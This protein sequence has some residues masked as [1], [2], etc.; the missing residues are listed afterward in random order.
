MADSDEE[1]PQAPLTP[2]EQGVKRDEHPVQSR[3]ADSA[4]ADRAAVKAARRCTVLLSSETP[5]AAGCVENLQASLIAAG[6]DTPRA[7]TK[8]T[9][10]NYERM[11]PPAATSAIVAAFRRF[12]ITGIGETIG[13]FVAEVH[14]GTFGLWKRKKLY[15]EEGKVWDAMD[16]EE[17]RL[18]ILAADNAFEGAKAYLGRVDTLSKIKLLK[19]DAADAALV[20]L[21]ARCVTGATKK[22]HP[23]VLVGGGS[24]KLAMAPRNGKFRV[25]LDHDVEGV[26]FEG[27]EVPRTRAQ[28]DEQ[29]VAPSCAEMQGGPC[30]KVG[31]RITSAT[32]TRDGL[33]DFSLRL[34]AARA[35]AETT[36]YTEVAGEIYDGGH[37]AFEARCEAATTRTGEL[38]EIYERTLHLS[39]LP[40]DAITKPRCGLIAD[41]AGAGYSYNNMLGIIDKDKIP[42]GSTPTQFVP[43][44]MLWRLQEELDEQ[45]PEERLADLFHR[46]KLALQREKPKEEL[47][48]FSE[49]MAKAS[50]ETLNYKLTVPTFNQAN[51]DKAESAFNVAEAARKGKRHA[52]ASGRW[53]L[54]LDPTMKLAPAANALRKCKKYLV[55]FDEDDFEELGELAKRM[56]HGAKTQPHLYP[57]S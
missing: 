50:P 7:S 42:E 1:L 32:V 16:G 33:D 31:V 13:Y 6:Q 10:Q 35:K 47:V 27:E 45:P 56:E 2:K 38:V 44:M 26:G 29:Y 48:L 41:E 43:T 17:R 53:R 8:D 3:E 4:R 57:V 15:V 23:V 37:A 54:P 24:G 46:R 51:W 18:R 36:A 55:L 14:R 22:G 9:A 39:C 11:A 28:I 20:G 25:V 49:Q 52:V 21:R 5:R 30:G 34:A 19:F 40:K 12:R